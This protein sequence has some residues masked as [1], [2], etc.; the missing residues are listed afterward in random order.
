MLDSLFALAENIVGVDRLVAELIVSLR[1]PVLTKLMTSVTGLGSATAALVMLGLFRTAGWR[2]LYLRG[3]V[4]LG[5]AGAVVGTLMIAV[6][7]PFP[8]GPVCMTDAA[9]AHS[10]P[11]G[12]AAA[13]TIYLL[14]AMG[15]ERLPTAA[16]AVVAIAIGLSR[17]YMG[18]HYV[19]DTVA[20]VAI[21]VGAFVIARWL[22][23]AG[24][25]VSIRARQRVSLR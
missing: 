4:S 13:A 1:H 19:S 23:A 8:P 3:V 18:T 5:L 7:R 20:G 25:D 21:G 24:E 9:I 2:T 15:S 12:H 17:I 10:F 6:Q 14:L 16:T 22:L 11:S